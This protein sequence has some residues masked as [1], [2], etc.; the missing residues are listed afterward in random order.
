MIYLYVAYEQKDIAKSLGAK[1]D[2]QKKLWYAP[3]NSFTKLLDT[4]SDLESKSKEKPKIIIQKQLNY[5]KFVGENTSFRKDEL[6]IDLVPKNTMFSLY[7]SLSKEDY[8]RLRD[9]LLKRAGYVC[10]ICTQDCKNQSNIFLCE[11]FSFSENTK[12]QKLEKIDV[13]CTKCFA[14]TRL[15]DKNIA[16]EHLQQVV[17]ISKD[18]AKHIIYDAFE[19]WKKKSGIQWNLDLSLLTNSGLKIKTKSA[20]QKDI[21]H[22]QEKLSNT[23]NIFISKSNTSTKGYS[24]Y[25][26]STTIQKEEECLL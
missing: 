10:E 9:T 26:S 7:H 8:Y 15:K 19:T 22:S 2:P 11:R 16:L 23:K 14:T 20:C 18:E 12:I 3:D 5:L 24:K 1:W 13:L 4:F 6:Y 21:R 17:D 25:N